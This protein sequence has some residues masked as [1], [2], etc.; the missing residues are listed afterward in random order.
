MTRHPLLYIINPNI[1]RGNTIIRPSIIRGRS[2]AC[3]TSTCNPALSCVQQLA[4]G[5]TH[6]RSAEYVVSIVAHASCDSSAHDP[7]W[8]TKRGCS[9]FAVLWGAAAGR[10]VGPKLCILTGWGK[11]D[12][13]LPHFADNECI[14][15]LYGELRV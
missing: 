8:V 5:L 15:I 12:S 3:L 6:K 9:H 2:L 4:N 14:L 11:N 7:C 13:Y 10:N 1:D